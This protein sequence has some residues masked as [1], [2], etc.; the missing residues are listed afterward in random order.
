MV[1]T[2]RALERLGDALT[3]RQ[4]S[5][6]PAPRTAVVALPLDLIVEPPRERRIRDAVGDV[7]LDKLVESLREN[8]LLHPVG[9]R[10]LADGH[11]EVV[12][13]GRRVAAARAL[14][15]TTIQAS[16]HLDLAEESAMVA[17][18]AENL[19]RKDLAQHELVAALRQ[20]ARL[21]RP[22]RPLGGFSTGGHAAIQPPPRQP[23]S[24]GDLARR[25]SVGV[26]TITRLAALGRDEQLLGLVEAGELGLT[27]ASH[28]ARLPGPLRPRMLEQIEHEHLS[29]RVVHVR[30]NALLRDR[31]A[32]VESTPTVAA[33]EVELSI[34]HY[35]KNGNPTP[36]PMLRAAELASTEPQPGAVLRRLRVVLGLLANVECVE[37]DP[38]QQLL[39]QI[40][41]HVDRLR[42]SRPGR[43][44]LAYA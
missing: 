20:L 42:A 29:S 26:D 14:G 15:W 27:T 33:A 41:E 16:L 32:V 36:L 8:G 40:G 10:S 19:H 44:V 9:V 18:L 5:Q 30:V 24:A 25:L 38:E 1:A 34:S 28:V 3:V 21:H 43:P 31:P 13:G 39:E 2:S 23:G 37:T 17:G 6:R 7:D 35:E 22:G 4:E 12:Y 11:F